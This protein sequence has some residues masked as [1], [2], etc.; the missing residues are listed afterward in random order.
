[1]TAPQVGAGSGAEEPRRARI[2]LICPRC[3]R[4]QQVVPGGPDRAVRVVHAG[5]GRE[6]CEPGDLATAPDDVG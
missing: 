1:M 4:E 6:A 5:T 2:P 3:G